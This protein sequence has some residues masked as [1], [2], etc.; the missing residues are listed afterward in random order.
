MNLLRGMHMRDNAGQGSQERQR[1][2]RLWS[3]LTLSNGE[4]GKEGRLGPII[5]DISAFQGKVGETTEELLSQSR[6][7]EGLYLPKQ[8]SLSLAGSSLWQVQC[9]CLGFRVQQL[10]FWVNYTPCN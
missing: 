2:V 7:L 9:H 10:G 8:G 3:G 6:W 1:T 4:T 5:S